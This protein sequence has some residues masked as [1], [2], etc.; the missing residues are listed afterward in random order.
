MNAIRCH[1]VSPPGR[2]VIA[3]P[4]RRAVLRAASAL[5]ALVALPS[6]GFAQ[7]GTAALAAGDLVDADGVASALA[8]RLAQTIVSVRGTLA[9]TPDGRVFT[10]AD[11]SVLPCQLCGALHDAGPSIGVETAR[12][13]PDAPAFERVQVSGRLEVGRAVRLTDARIQAA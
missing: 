1:A 10:V 5:A 11:G 2:R 6:P 3:P 4:G 13:E 7:P 8:Q 9:P 12:P